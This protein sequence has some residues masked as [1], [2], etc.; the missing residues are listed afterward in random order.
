MLNQCLQRTN[1]MKYEIIHL[2]EENLFFVMVKES[3]ITNWMPL[4][5]VH[6][7]GKWIIERRP[8]TVEKH[9]DAIKFECTVVSE[10]QAMDRLNAY[11]K[12]LRAELQK[13]RDRM[14]AKQQE[15]NN[16]KVVKRGRI[17]I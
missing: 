12:H 6:R 11:V 10:D 15:K 17:K 8:Y 16:M 14:A 5:S 7:G 2:Q 1:K 3:W 9:I 4:A 13:E